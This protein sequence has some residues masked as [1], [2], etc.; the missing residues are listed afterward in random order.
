M[1]AEWFTSVDGR[2]LSNVE[3]KSKAF[4]AVDSGACPET[5]RARG[6]YSG[7]FLGIVLEGVCNADTG[8]SQGTAA[9]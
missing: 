8:A 7:L 5:R 4:L 3:V 2:R 9:R 1:C 6:L